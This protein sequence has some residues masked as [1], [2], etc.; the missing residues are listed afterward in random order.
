LVVFQVYGETHT[1]E[2]LAEVTL[3]VFAISEQFNWHNETVV[4]HVYSELQLHVPFGAE[5]V[6]FAFGSSEQLSTQVLLL[7]NQLYGVLQT[8][9]PAGGI[10]VLLTFASP[11]QLTTH[12]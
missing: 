11:V 3:F 2:L 9:A 5:V 6:V 1:H 10:A 8:H 7:L 4:F 12:L